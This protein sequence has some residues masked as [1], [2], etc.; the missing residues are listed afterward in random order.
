MGVPGG[1]THGGMTAPKGLR[2]AWRTPRGVW[3]PRWGGYTHGGMTAPKVWRVR[4]TLAGVW[5]LG[6]GCHIHGGMNL[7]NKI[8]FDS[9]RKR[10]LSFSIENLTKC[11]GGVQFRIIMKA[12]FDEEKEKKRKQRKNEQDN[13]NTLFT[14]GKIYICKFFR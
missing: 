10:A 12:N 3:L 6:W 7:F 8:I 14:M 4:Q 2:R 13:Y 5:L 9:N 11:C 1:Y